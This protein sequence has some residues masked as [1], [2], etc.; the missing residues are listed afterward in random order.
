MLPSAPPPSRP[1]GLADDLGIQR[2]GTGRTPQH[3]SPDPCPR[4]AALKIRTTSQ[5]P[6]SPSLPAIQF[7]A[8]APS[9]SPSL[10]SRTPAPT[11]AAPSTV[12][13]SAC[14]WSVFRRK[15]GSGP[16]SISADRFINLKLG[17]RL[18]CSPAPSR[19]LTL[20]ILTPSL[21]L[22]V[23]R[24]APSFRLLLAFAAPPTPQCSRPPSVPKKGRATT[25]RESGTS[26][27]GGV[28]A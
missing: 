23:P 11:P 16:G 2:F 20:Q 27:F 7:G 24:R 1:V 22:R 9:W 28:W 21:S 4:P 25:P 26:A 17:R 14:A 18:G 10:P 13:G 3:P 8:S 15:L 19:S 6:L 5:L 12:R